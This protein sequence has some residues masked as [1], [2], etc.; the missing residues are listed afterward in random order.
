MYTKPRFCCSSLFLF[1]LVL[2]SHLDFITP[3]QLDIFRVVL[4]SYEAKDALHLK[5]LLVDLDVFN[6]DTPLQIGE[7]NSACI[8]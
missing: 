4:P 6:P 3:T 5:Q 2:V 8:A 1:L 7:D